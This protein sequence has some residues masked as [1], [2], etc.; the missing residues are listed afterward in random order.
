MPTNFPF[1]IKHRFGKCN[2]AVFTHSFVPGNT[3]SVVIMG[4]F[5]AIYPPL[6][7][8]Q[9]KFPYFLLAQI[10]CLSNRTSSSD[11]IRFFLNRKWTKGKTR[12]D[13]AL[14]IS[15]SV[16]IS[17]FYNIR[18]IKG[19]FI[20]WYII[21]KNKIFKTLSTPQAHKNEK[22]ELWSAFIHS[23]PLIVQQCIVHYHSTGKDSWKCFG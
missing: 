10:I 20:R 4:T 2:T 16:I 5:T 18:S 15:S 21:C 6:Q 12:S 13:G 9:K 17:L 19:I 23:K 14:F 7:K 22:H 3:V 11:L 8:W 1:H